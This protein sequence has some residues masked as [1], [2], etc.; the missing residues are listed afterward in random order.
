MHVCMYVCYLVCAFKGVT[1]VCVCVCV[2]VLFVCLLNTFNS[3]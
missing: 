3:T 2:H 1:G